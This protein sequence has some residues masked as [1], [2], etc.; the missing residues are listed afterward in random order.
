[1]CAYACVYVNSIHLFVYLSSFSPLL[2][3]FSFVFLLCLWSCLCLIYVMFIF[4]FYLSPYFQA[5]FFVQVCVSFICN[6]KCVC[7]CVWKSITAIQN[8]F[9]PDRNETNK[10]FVLP[11]CA[12]VYKVAFSIST[13]TFVLALFH[14]YFFFLIFFL[15][16]SH[17]YFF[18][19]SVF[20]VPHFLISSS[21]SFAFS[22]IIM[23]LI[24]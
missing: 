7:V 3:F 19:S 18:F 6:M 2:F 8:R 13:S 11:V 20:L 24:F 15:S 12:S 22:S 10:L 4:L 9:L 17:L 1:M 16:L 5:S 14:L 21:F 23:F